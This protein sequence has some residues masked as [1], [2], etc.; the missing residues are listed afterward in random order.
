M[1]TPNI[2]IP[3]NQVS[4]KNSAP[5]PSSNIII[6]L[7]K[8]LTFAV[9][10]LVLVG[11]GLL[12]LFFI[13]GNSNTLSFDRVLWATVIAA[14]TLSLAAVAT[15]FKKRV[16][17]VRPTAL[18]FLALFVVWGFISA[19]V[20]GDSYDSI[21]GSNV[22]TLT[23]I[24]SLLLLLFTVLPLLLQSS[25]AML[26]RALSAMQG[27]SLV[28]L[29]HT[30]LWYWFGFSFLGLGELTNANQSLLGGFNDSGIYAGVI[31]LFTLIT[32]VMLPLRTYV[33]LAVSFILFLSLLVLLV[34]NFSLVW[35]AIL[36]VSAVTTAY[37]LLRKQLFQKVALAPI[38]RLTKI[39][40]L[41]TFVVAGVAVL[42]GTLIA[43][44]L[45]TVAKTQFV[46]V[47]PSFEA[48]ADIM[49]AVY[50]DSP[51]FGIGPNRYDDAWRQHKDLE[52]NATVFWNTDFRVGDSYMVSVFTTYGLVGG[53]LMMLF[54]LGFVWFGLSRL[55]ANFNGNV[56][57]RYVMTVSFVGAVFLWAMTYV[58][59]PGVTILL[60]AAALTGLTF[61]SSSVFDSTRQVSVELVTNRVRGF[62]A[63][64]TA[65]L[66]VVLAATFVQALLTKYTEQINPSVVKDTK[67]DEVMGVQAN[68]RITELNQLIARANPESV[69]QDDLLEASRAALTTSREAIDLDPTNP[70]HHQ[71][72]AS[73]YGVLGAIGVD[74][75]YR[76][77]K[78]T[79][80]T[81]IELDPK[82]PAHHLATA[83]ILLAEGEVET[84]QEALTRATN[85][86]FNYTEAIQLQTN[87]A[88]ANND[89]EETITQLENAVQ[90]Q[91]D[92]ATL[93]YQLGVLHAATG[94]TDEAVQALIRSLQFDPTYA[95]AR[96]V[97]ALQYVS[98]DRRERAV[99]QLRLVEETN[100]DNQQL[101]DL[102]ASIEA[103]EDIEIVTEPPQLTSEEP[104][105]DNESGVSVPSGVSSD[106]FSPVNPSES[107]D[108]S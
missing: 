35:L 69:T 55:L 26:L 58:Y 23:V 31:V 80:E 20:H 3:S 27:A 12:P 79:L 107:A 78:E 17:S 53:L 70:V 85:L 65:V 82:N 88:I 89:A 29:L 83:R 48:S 24:F 47:L 99:S 39:M 64:F 77:A 44:N 62:V 52:V 95:D 30:L 8:Y 34:V 11:I 63:L 101:Q 91:P 87:I 102:I 22:E 21:F 97:L 25:T 9:Q 56:V 49:R 43:Q 106:L 73:L 103:G 54:H 41:I 7:N 38:S 66:V 105:V 4:E 93:W 1:S 42:Y 108:G 15:L 68:E 32:L 18:L 94:N 67:N 14:T 51:L 96:Y 60:L 71:R 86:K 37:V 40:S 2:F 5:Q 61:A 92:N 84:A 10:S 16:E 72:L 45:S 13:L 46:E 74:G 19:F 36:V 76:N 59:T 104:S 57:I 81:V 33:Q 50:E 100:P 75:A 28:V 90:L 98:Q 6:T